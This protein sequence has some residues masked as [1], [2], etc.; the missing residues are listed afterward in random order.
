M[1]GYHKEYNFGAKIGKHSFPFHSPLTAHTFWG[2]FYF[3]YIR[4]RG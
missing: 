2:G 4:S 1:E 3:S